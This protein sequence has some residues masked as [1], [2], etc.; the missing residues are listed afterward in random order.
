MNAKQALDELFS[1]YNFDT[2]FYKK[3]VYNNIEFI[4]KNNEHRQLF[5]SRLIGCFHVKY[6]TYEK[7]IFYNNLFNLE[8]EDVVKAIDKINTINKTFKIA[9]DDINLVTFY[10]AHRFLSNENLSKDKRIEYAKEILNYFSYRTLILLSSMY[11]VY[12]ISEEKALTL[13]EKLSNRYVIK[14]LKNWNEY[15]QYRSEEYLNSKYMDF[16]IKFNKDIDLPN[17]INDLYGRTKDTLKNIYI[18]FMDMLEKDEIIKSKSNVVSDI[19]G[20]EVILDKLNTPEVYFS[21]VESLLSDKNSFIKKDLID[22]T[23]DIVNTVSFKN[24]EEALSYILD[25]SFKD[26]DSN[27]AVREFI[28]DVLINCIEYLH[29]NNIYLSKGSNVLAV[30]NHVVGNILFARGTDVDINK[31]KEKGDKLIKTVY[32]SSKKYITDRNVK[33]MRNAIYVYIVLVAIIQR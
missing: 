11:F 24:L 26:K 23:I 29:R 31:L 1:N 17:A 18:E 30:I 8:T 21:K 12:P 14:K 32:K 4:T 28:N 15:C 19:E 27:I 20:Q 13:T 22:V 25:F 5:G 10:I 16:L 9:R 7:N 6:T 3:L 33:N 2:A